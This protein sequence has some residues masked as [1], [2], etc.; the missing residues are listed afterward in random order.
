MSQIYTKG[1]MCLCDPLPRPIARQI[2]PEIQ[3]LRAIL[4]YFICIYLA[5]VAHSWT[6]YIIKSEY[7]P[8]FTSGPRNP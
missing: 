2:A 8:W 4:F 6:T 1:S 3:K 7:C 5:R